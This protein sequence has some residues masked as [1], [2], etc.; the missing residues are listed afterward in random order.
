MPRLGI[1]RSA[2]QLNGLKQ[3]AIEKGIELIPLPLTESIPTPFELPKEVSFDSTDWVMFTSKNGV[4]SFFSQTKELL[5]ENIKIAVIGVKTEEAVRKHNHT[6]TFVA[7]SA[8]GKD[9]LTQFTTTIDLSGKTILY[10]RAE[11]VL[12]QPE[13]YFNK[14]DCQFHQ[15][16]CYKTI[17]CELPSDTQEL[18]SKEDFL[19]FTAPSAVESFRRQFGRP[20]AKIIAIGKTTEEA[21]LNINWEISNR[22]EKP[23]IESVL[24]YI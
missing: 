12:T 7:D 19:F 14:L 10:F 1:T 6:V 8:V 5:P 20:K 13:K 11:H 22:L 9:F 23:D 16:I 24:E 2:D 17:E 15:I 4:D 3:K 18:F 21:I